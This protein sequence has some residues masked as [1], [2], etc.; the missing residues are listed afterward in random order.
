MTSDHSAFVELV[1]K[2]RAEGAVR[3]RDGSLEVALPVFLEALEGEEE[4]REWRSGLKFSLAV[5]APGKR[6]E[7][8]EATYEGEPVKVVLR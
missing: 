7:I 1:L 8:T 4:L 6:T 3:V 2:L 5:H